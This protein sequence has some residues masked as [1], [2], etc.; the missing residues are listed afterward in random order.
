[1]Q[2]TTF[3]IILLLFSSAKIFAQLR[4]EFNGPFASWANVKTRFNAKGD[5]KADDTK[6]LQTAIDSLSCIPLGFNKDAATAYTCIYIPKGHYKISQT[7]NLRGKIGINI[8]GEDPAD[9]FIEWA[10]NDTD[11]MLLANGSAYYKIA[12]LTFDARNKRQIEGIGIHWLQKWN[13]P[14]SRSYASLNNEIGDCIFSGNMAIGIGGGYNWNDS[15][16]KINRCTFDKCKVAGVRITGYNA[17]DYWIWYCKFLNCYSGISSMSGNF[18]A[19]YCYFKQSELTDVESDKGYYTSIRGC[20]SDNSNVFQYDKGSSSN[21]FKRIFQDNVISAPYMTPVQY[22]H[23]GKLTFLNNQFDGL[24]GKQP[25]TTATGDKPYL[26]YYASWF[27]TNYNVLSIGNN[28]IYEQPFA[29]S[30][31][32]PKKIYGLNDSYGKKSMPKGSD[33]VAAMPVTPAF[34]KRVIFEIPVK[35][36]ANVIQQIINNAA[37]L[38]GQRPIVHFPVSQYVIDKTIVIPKGSDMQ[39]VGDGYIYASTLV[40]AKPFTGTSMIKVKG[41]SYIEIRDLEI[42][43]G[44]AKYLNSIEFENID[45]PS[46][47][48]HIDQLYSQADTSL[49]VN[50]LNYTSFEKNNSFFSDGNVVIGGN[51]Q[52]NGNGTMSVNCFGGQYTGVSV[53]NNGVFVAK[54]CW[55]EGNARVPLN[56]EGD[57]SITVDGAMMAPAKVDSLPSIKIGKFNGTISF[58]NMYIQGGVAFTDQI[59]NSA[60]VLFWNILFYHEMNVL[61]SIPASMK[62]QVAFAGINAQCF[63]SKNPLCK[64]IQTVNDKFVNVSDEN[65]YFDTMTTQDRLAAPSLYKNLNAGVSNI[66]LGRVTLE[67]CLVGLKFYK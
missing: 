5:G 46:S 60:K 61:G 24:R 13:E 50:G 36:N 11:T 15:E 52:K 17:L 53:S 22:S 37:K 32:Y 38:A 7:L 67:G 34:K 18:H 12:R 41:P 19:Y 28:Y 42:S 31:K 54:D 20:F 21:P 65:K 55:W 58:L 64:D 30:S 43:N 39:I 44:P 14:K 56:L 33:F 49:F 29:I 6:A 10:G 1:M 40:M 8:I 2:K 47:S 9:T 48:V 4:E 26:I 35:A 66:Y 3:F 51:K 25:P 27:G 63:D 45:Q 62:G 23:I 57:G 59:N 16:I